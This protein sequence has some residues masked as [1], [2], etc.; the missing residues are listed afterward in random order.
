VRIKKIYFLSLILALIKLLVAYLV[1][2]SHNLDFG[3]SLIGWD[4]LQWQNAATF[5]YEN[6]YDFNSIKLSF[7]LDGGFTNGGWP[8]LIGLLHY[9]VG[10][11]YFNAV[12]LRVIL[13]LIACNAFYTILIRTGHGQKVTIISI[14]FLAFY[15]PFFVADATY[16]RD[17]IVVYLIII[18]LRLAM[19]RGYLKGILA[20]VLFLLTAYVLILS[21]P[22]AFLVFISL[23]L[24]YFKCFRWIHW[25]LLIPPFLCMI[26]LGTDLLSY[27]M[28][29][30]SYFR[31]DV[32]NILVSSFK[33]YIGPLPWNMIG[34]DSGYNPLWYALTLSLIL[35]GF[36]L[37][38][39]YRS[40]ALNWRVMVALFMTGLFPYI[41]SNQEVDAVGP[42]QFAMVGPFLFVILYG[43]IIKNISIKRSESYQTA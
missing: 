19:V 13:F 32:K 42:R 18:L 3:K 4:E 11:H 9:I 7:G 36:T 26:F 28:N 23:Y 21:R 2:R 41:I 30:L 33:Y 24:F 8:Y 37:P 15:H 20:V 34:I 16:L 27:G 1:Y 12:I 43:D 22:F 5:F 31:F 40:L 35:L 25:V 6:G 39:F 29:F 14:L 17:D 10:Y 38:A